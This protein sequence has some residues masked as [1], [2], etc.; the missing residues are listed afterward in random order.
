MKTILTLAFILA[1]GLASATEL[2]V[3]K[4]KVAMAKS[5]PPLVVIPGETCMQRVER[6]CIVTHRTK[7]F[8]RACVRRN[9]YRCR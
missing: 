2:K 8:T 3:P 4:G 7:L 1:A 5:P 6:A 9:A